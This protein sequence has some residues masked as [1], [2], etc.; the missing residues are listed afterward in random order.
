MPGAR[1]QMLKIFVA[2]M[3]AV[4]LANQSCNFRQFDREI[5]KSL[6]NLIHLNHHFR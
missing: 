1:D 3:A 4:A 5:S 6:V 2:A